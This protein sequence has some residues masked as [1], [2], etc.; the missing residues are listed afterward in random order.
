MT[1]MTMVM[2]PRRR[3]LDTT[4]SADARRAVS[5]RGG[6]K[7]RRLKTPSRLPQTLYLFTVAFLTAMTFL[8]FGFSS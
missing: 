7:T 1:M 2:I 4:S 3:M 8:R 6:S 5:S